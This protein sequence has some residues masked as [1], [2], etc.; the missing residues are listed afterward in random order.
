MLGTRFAEVAGGDVGEPLAI[1]DIK[2]YLEDQ[3]RR[4]RGGEET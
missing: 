3:A 1:M 4:S 2:R